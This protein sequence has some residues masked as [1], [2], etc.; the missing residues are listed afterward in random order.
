MA[1]MN[2]ARSRNLEMDGPRLAQ[3]VTATKVAPAHPETPEHLTWKPSQVLSHSHLYQS[4]SRLVRNNSRSCL[5]QPQELDL[6]IRATISS[7]Q[8]CYRAC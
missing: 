7:K 3:L 2:H 1:K 8:T 4:C 5:H 6:G